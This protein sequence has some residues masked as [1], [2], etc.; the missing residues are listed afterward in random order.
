MSIQPINLPSNRNKVLPKIA[1]GG[2]MVLALS[3]C[4]SLEKPSS[5]EFFEAPTP[6]LLKIEEDFFKT[7]GL[8]N[9]IIEYASDSKLPAM[10]GEVATPLY[11]YSYEFNGTLNQH[12][13]TLV[14]AKRDTVKMSSVYTDVENPSLKFVSEPVELNESWSNPRFVETNPV[15][16]LEYIALNDGT[17]K[18]V[19]NSP[20]Y[21]SSVRILKPGKTT[22]EVL[23]YDTKG[24]L[25]E[26]YEKLK[27]IIMNSD[28]QAKSALKALKALL[29]K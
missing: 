29:K 8:L 3:S 19:S 28:P 13:V 12:N 27:I 7:F 25:L 24:R 22:G 18:R 11:G 1:A 5:A 9:P 26:V 14:D 23:S 10:V 17:V 4:T 20:L 21:G 16:S 15:S 2:A 6:K